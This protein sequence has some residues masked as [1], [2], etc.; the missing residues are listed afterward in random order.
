MI[1]LGILVLFMILGILPSFNSDGQ[2]G[3][4]LV[5]TSLQ[6]L[7]LGQFV[8]SQVTRSWLV[9]AFG[10]LCAAAGIF[11]C[12]VPGILTGVIQ[13]L[14]GLQ[15]ITT[16]VLLL[17]TKIIAP[18]LYGIRHPPAEPVTLPPIVKRLFRVLTA[19]GIVTILFGINMLAPLLLPSLLGMV[20]YAIII[21][22]LIIIMGFLSLIMVTITQK[23]Q[24]AE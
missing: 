22:L 14:I 8:G 19:T 9:I 23:L 3:L 20:V 6:L 10:I 17:A 1:L 13:P 4:L 12:I 7:A 11:S 5:L 21:P 24:Q 2:L 15:N 18:T 16:G